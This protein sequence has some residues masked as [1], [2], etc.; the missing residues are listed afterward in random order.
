MSY[1]KLLYVLIIC[2]TYRPV[3][4]NA[5]GVVDDF[6]VIDVLEDEDHIPAYT[7]CFDYEDF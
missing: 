4:E 3:S 6:D 2:P 1:A 7:G 5:R